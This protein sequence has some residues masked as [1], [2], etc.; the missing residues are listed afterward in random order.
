MKPL[1]FTVTALLLVAASVAAQGDEKRR[2]TA[3]DGDVAAVLSEFQPLAEQGLREAQYQLGVLYE[4]GRGIGQD[5]TKAM[6][7]YRLAAEQ[8][9]T[10][11]QRAVGRMHYLGLGVPQDVAEA[12]IWFRRADPQFDAE[13]EYVRGLGNLLPS[14]LNYAEAARW[15]RRAAERGYADAQYEL[16]DLY[17]LGQ[18]VPRDYAEA[19]KWYHSAAEQGQA[20]AQL[21]LGKLI[22]EGRGVPQDKTQAQMWLNLAVA[23]GNESAR[24]YRDKVTARMTAEQLLE[25]QDRAREWAAKHGGTDSK[26]E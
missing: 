6:T 21:A 19:G 10:E 1:W 14:Q 23:Q 9:L 12:E 11:A 20:D 18:G 3:L 5:Y 13:D 25:A 2:E 8:G 24:A 4:G 15:F 16:G 17:N 22:W 7:W 26:P